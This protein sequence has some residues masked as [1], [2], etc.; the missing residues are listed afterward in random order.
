[1]VETPRRAQKQAGPAA[2]RIFAANERI[3]QIILEQL[4]ASIWK[5]KPPGSVRT[6]AA[7]FTHMHNVRVKWIRLTALHLGVPPQLNRACT[8]QQARASLTESGA[9]CAE[10]LTSALSGV[11]ERI[12][13]FHRDGWAREWPAGMEMLSYM[14]VHEAHH[15]GQVCLLAHQ[16]GFPLSNEVMSKTWDWVKI[17]KDCGWPKGPG[18]EP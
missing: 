6:I 3:N 11:D 4:D 8:P 10:M 16:L 17:W 9:R 14:L 2:G 13:T 7:I 1:M 15:R 12:Q 5:A 18:Y